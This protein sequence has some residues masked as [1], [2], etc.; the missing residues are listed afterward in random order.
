[1]KNKNYIGGN[2][3]LQFAITETVD[4][5]SADFAPSTD[6]FNKGFG[7]YISDG[8]TLKFKA[9]GDDDWRSITVPDNHYPNIAFKAISKDSSCVIEL[10]GI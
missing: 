6:P 2:V 9:I 7:V 8:G 5:S 1:M 4:L 10:A 3:I